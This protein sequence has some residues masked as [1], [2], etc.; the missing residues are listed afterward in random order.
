MTSFLKEST[1]LVARPLPRQHV[2][3]S[4]AAGIDTFA[5]LHVDEIL[6]ENGDPGVGCAVALPSNFLHAPDEIAI[7]I[8]AGT[9]VTDGIAIT[10]ERN[11]P[12]ISLQ[13]SG[14]YLVV[15][16]HCR[17][18]FFRLVAG[19]YTVFTIESDGRLIP[20]ES[21]PD[22]RVTRDIAAIGTLDNLKLA[23]RRR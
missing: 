15:G 2:I 19:P 18:G 1:F 12:D 11:I 13:A 17:S 7:S 5:A 14:R 8:A 20:L 22:A 10:S 21:V 23:L 6:L 3:F 9:I 16:D 4:S